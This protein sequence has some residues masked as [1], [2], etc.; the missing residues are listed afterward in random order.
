MNSLAISFGKRIPKMQ[1]FI[2]RKDT[3]EF[4]PAIFSEVDCKDYEDYTDVKKLDRKWTFK[5]SIAQRIAEKNSMQLYLKKSTGTSV[6]EMHDINGELIGLVQTETQNGI[7][8]IEYIESKPNNEYRY[9]GQSIV[10]AIGQEALT[11]NCHLLTVLAPV[12]DAIPFYTNTCGFKRFGEFS[13]KMNFKQ[14]QEL[15]EKTAQ[16]TNAPIINLQG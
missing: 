12:D 8:N 10:T 2:Q 5:D 11:K 6:Y 4:V 16:K 3:E 9:V 15:I 1:F 13:L 14:I 7:C